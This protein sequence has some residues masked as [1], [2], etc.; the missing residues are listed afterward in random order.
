GGPDPEAAR[1]LAR[2]AAAQGVRQV[3][4]LHAAGA[5]TTA[6]AGVFTAASEALRGSVL[7]HVPY[8]P[9]TAAALTPLPEI[10][11]NLRPQALVVAAPA[12][13]LPALAPRFTAAALSALG[14]RVLATTAWADPAALARVPAQ[15][16]QGMVTVAAASP[17][18]P[19]PGLATFEAAYRDR[20]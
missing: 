4:V 16:T 5:E 1:T 6:E 3:V 13:D 2:H 19:P 9:T 12:A 18:S 17:A 11:R 20:F 8:G 15:H 10:V 7:R 14:I